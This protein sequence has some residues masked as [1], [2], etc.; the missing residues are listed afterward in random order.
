MPI[1]YAA[2]GLPTFLRGKYRETPQDTKEVFEPSNGRVLTREKFTDPY[3]TISGEINV[4][5]AQ[6]ATFKTFY[7]TDTANGALEF[8]FPHPVDGTIT[9]L[10]AGPYDIAEAG[11]NNWIISFSLWRLP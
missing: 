11:A 6:R 1:D 3:V 2:T 7:H 9:C 8:S 5:T 10:F 4:T